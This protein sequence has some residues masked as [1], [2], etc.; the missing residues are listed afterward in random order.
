M[1]ANYELPNRLNP[2]TGL[3]SSGESSTYKSLNLYPK[4]PSLGRGSDVPQEVRSSHSK[5]GAQILM[6]AIAEEAVSSQILMWGPEAIA[7]QH[8]L[9]T[10]T[11]FY[12]VK[13]SATRC[14]DLLVHHALTKQGAFW[15]Q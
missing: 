5:C 4:N 14:R 8:L 10:D 1:E 3:P 15:V 9:G 2:S 6:V 11:L 12:H 7:V 13:I